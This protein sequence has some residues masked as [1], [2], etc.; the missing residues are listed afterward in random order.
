MKSF[1]LLCKV[2]SGIT[3]DDRISLNITLLVEHA[4]GKQ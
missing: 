2:C 1:T 3:L 4:E